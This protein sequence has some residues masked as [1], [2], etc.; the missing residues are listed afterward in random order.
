MREGPL[1]AA[2]LLAGMVAVFVWTIRKE[3]RE[4]E[5]TEGVGQM[6]ANV[7]LPEHTI[8]TRITAVRIATGEYLLRCGDCADYLNQGR[9]YGAD[10]HNLADD[11]K[12]HRRAHEMRAIA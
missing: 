7:E 10:D 12:W 8:H 6:L 2:A 3:R 9:R 4:H 5:W 1:Y 11:A